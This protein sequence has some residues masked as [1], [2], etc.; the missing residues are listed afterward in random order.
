MVIF[1]RQLRAIHC[2]KS[3]IFIVSDQ[4]P[5]RLNANLIGIGSLI[6]MQIKLNNVLI[7]KINRLRFSPIYKLAPLHLKRTSILSETK[8]YFYSN[9]QSGNISPR[10]SDKRVKITPDSDLKIPFRQR[11]FRES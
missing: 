1:G 6:G 8:T 4:E 9:R 2:N 3:N 11:A 7:Y 5:W 10:S